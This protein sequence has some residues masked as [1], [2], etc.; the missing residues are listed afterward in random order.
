MK[1]GDI[2]ILVED[3]ILESG[4]TKMVLSRGTKLKVSDSSYFGD[5]SKF[6]AT[7]DGFSIQSID[8]KIA[9]K[10]FDVNS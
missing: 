7:I 10:D 1:T 2:V 4:D 6:C 9:S 8:K 3:L 5:Q